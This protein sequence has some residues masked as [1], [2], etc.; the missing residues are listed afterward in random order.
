[1]PRT[2]S[3]VVQQYNAAL[4]RDSSA[5]LPLPPDQHHHSD[6]ATGRWRIPRK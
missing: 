1:V 2:A 5:T 6:V 3:V 4:H